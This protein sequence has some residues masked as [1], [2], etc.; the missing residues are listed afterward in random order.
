MAV[1]FI[2]RKAARFYR[3]WIISQA[4]FVNTKR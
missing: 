1:L 3:F 4:E 2:L